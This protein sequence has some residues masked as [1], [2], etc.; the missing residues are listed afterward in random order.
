M[1][2]IFLSTLIAL[3]EKLGKSFPAQRAHHLFRLHQLFFLFGFFLL[4]LYKSPVLN[5]SVT[6]RTGDV[7]RLA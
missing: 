2:F 4:G 7:D 3:R 6:K 1:A 5:K